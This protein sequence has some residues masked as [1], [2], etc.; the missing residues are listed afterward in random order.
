MSVY[1]YAVEVEYDYEGSQLLL[2]TTS[3]RAAFKCADEHEGGD[4][5]EVSMWLD[6][7][8]CRTWKRAR[9][10]EGYN[11]RVCIRGEWKDV[12]P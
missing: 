8:C 4:F 1:V 9:G 10:A 3:K 7:K 11:E 2:C 12:Q 6:G 5:V